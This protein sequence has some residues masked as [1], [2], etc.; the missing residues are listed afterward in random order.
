MITPEWFKNRFNEFDLVSDIKIQIFIDEATTI[1][2][3]LFWGK[4]YDLGLGY[5]SAHFLT[6]SNQTNT[7]NVEAAGAVTSK[8]V[9]GVSV[10]LGIPVGEN[11]SEAFYSST[12]YGQR[13][14]TLRKTLGVACG[15]V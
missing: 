3:K 13:Y 12:V 2:N 15:V 1:L 9:D 10:T 8:A 7:G 6:L 11:Q 4:K 14:L 5:L